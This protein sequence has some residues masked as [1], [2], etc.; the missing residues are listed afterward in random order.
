MLGADLPET[1]APGGVEP[2]FVASR[3]LSPTHAQGMDVAEP[4]V[5]RNLA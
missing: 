5:A 4:T 3:F 1:Q 2:A